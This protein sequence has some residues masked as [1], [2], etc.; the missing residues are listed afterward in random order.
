MLSLEVDAR[1][2]KRVVLGAAAEAKTNRIADCDS[3]RQ[4]DM[5]VGIAGSGDQPTT[6]FCQHAGSAWCD[7]LDV[8]SRGFAETASDAHSDGR[9]PHMIAH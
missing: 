4:R 2:R 5:M 1:D 6:A 3:R 8:M 9:Y 7:S